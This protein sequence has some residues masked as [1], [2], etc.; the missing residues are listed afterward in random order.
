MKTSSSSWDA[1][2]FHFPPDASH[3]PSALVPMWPPRSSSCGAIGVAPEPHPPPAARRADARRVVRRP[4]SPAR[5][6]HRDRR[7]RARGRGVA[8]VGALEPPPSPSG[9]AQPTK[10][11]GPGSRA[12][13]DSM[14]ARRRPRSAATVPLRPGRGCGRPLA[15]RHK[16]RDECADYFQLVARPRSERLALEILSRRSVVPTPHRGPL[17][18]R[19]TRRRRVR[20]HARAA[21]AANLIHEGFGF[22][23]LASA[24]A[25]SSARVGLSSYAPAARRSSYSAMAASSSS[26]GSR[27]TRNSA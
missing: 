4:P 24:S 9:R 7:A 13:R 23:V 27:S 19:A 16:R 12:A 5:G 21:P 25:I 10:R 8:A 20:S 2:V 14:R 1:P 26:A 6:A 3:R 18:P 17:R 22:L 11:S 15:F